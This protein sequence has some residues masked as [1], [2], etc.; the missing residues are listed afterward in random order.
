MPGYRGRANPSYSTSA[1]SSAGSGFLYPYDLM[2]ER[3][4]KDTSPCLQDVIIGTTVSF[5]S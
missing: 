5:P 2:A 1:Q 4:G 3:G